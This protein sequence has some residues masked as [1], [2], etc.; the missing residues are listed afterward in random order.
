VSRRDEML[1]CR[2]ENLFVREIVSDAPRAAGYALLV[3]GNTFPSLADFDLPVEGRS[4]AEHVA[5]SG[6]DCCIFDHRGYGRSYKPRSLGEVSLA[7]KVHDL[8]VVHSYLVERRRAASIHLLGLSTGCQTIAAFLGRAP[9]AVRSIVLMGPCYSMNAYMEK[10]MRR[11]WLGRMVN[12]MLGRPSDP[13]VSFSRRA[14]SRRLLAGEEKL[15]GR[16]VFD[17][18]VDAALDGWPHGTG[19]L[20]SPVLGYPVPAGPV[21]RGGAMYDVCNISLPVL[22]VRGERDEICCARTVEKL[23]GDLSTKDVETVVVPDCKHDLH[24]YPEP[25]RIFDR[26]AA[27]LLSQGEAGP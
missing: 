12:R 20:R 21:A 7:E 13:Y 24:L 6:L 18:F 1:S 15:I 8:E 17:A 10:A 14:L 23:V 5:R 3:H 4:L 19:R 22:V 16:D 11:L 9:Q 27:F 26:I 2:G 25:G